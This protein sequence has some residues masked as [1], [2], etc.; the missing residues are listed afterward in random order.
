MKRSKRYNEIKAKVEK[1]EYPLN[2]AIQFIKDNAN[3]KFDET[4]EVSI[5]LGVDPRKSDQMVRG[6]VFLPNGTGKKIKILVFAVGEK[7]SEAKEAGAD[8]VG[9]DELI[10]KIAKGWTDFDLA[11]SVPEMMAKVGKIGRILGPRGLMPNPKVGTVTKDIKKAINEAK[12]GRVEFKIDKT[13]N[14]HIPIGKVSFEPEKIEENL[15]EVLREVI[16]LKPATSKGTY[17]KSLYLSSSMG[18]SVKINA[19]ETIKEIR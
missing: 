6:T 3:T 15:I 4:V 8:Y 7:E 11:I 17:I 2:E 1:K 9:G 5:R 14:L 16:R 10:D 13:A 19:Q 12:K 18:P